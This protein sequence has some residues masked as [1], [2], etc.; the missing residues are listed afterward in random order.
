MSFPNAI[1]A[2]RT[3]LF[4]K[5]VELQKRYPQI[6][7]DK[8]LHIREMYNWFISNPDGTDREFLSKITQRHDIS[9]VTAYSDLAKKVP[10]CYKS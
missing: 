8:I 6:L 1:E 9:R 2:C 4:T 3:D 7:V 10:D 5:E